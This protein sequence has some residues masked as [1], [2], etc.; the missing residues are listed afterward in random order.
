MILYTTSM[1]SNFDQAYCHHMSALLMREYSSARRKPI[2]I[3]RSGVLLATVCFLK[4]VAA[5]IVN[6]P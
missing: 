3:D 4:R 1:P 6:H 5:D 2:G